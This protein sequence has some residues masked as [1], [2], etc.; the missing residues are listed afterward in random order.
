[1]PGVPR[2]DSKPYRSV[3][4][5]WHGRSRA[6]SVPIGGRASTTVRGVS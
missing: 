6:A 2:G 1:M 4:S 5:G 3:D